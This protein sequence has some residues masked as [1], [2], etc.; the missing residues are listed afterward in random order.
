VDLL[1]K[2]I[3]YIWSELFYLLSENRKCDP[4]IWDFISQSL[5]TVVRKL[6]VRLTWYNGTMRLFCRC[7][8]KRQFLSDGRLRKNWRIWCDNRTPCIFSLK[9]RS[10]PV[11]SVNISGESIKKTSFVWNYFSRSECHQVPSAGLQNLAQ[12]VLW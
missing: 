10:E 4:L 2:G 5:A 9:D 1:I 6:S 3:K 7:S 8:D 11:A 12:N